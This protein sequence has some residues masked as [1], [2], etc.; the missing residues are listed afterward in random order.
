MVVLSERPKCTRAQKDVE[1]CSHL[2]HPCQISGRYKGDSA[3]SMS[4]RRTVCL[5]FA[6]APTIRTDIPLLSPVRQVVE[7][8]VEQPVEHEGGAQSTHETRDRQVALL[9]GLP[10]GSP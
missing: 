5:R 6:L 10:I 2:R 9:G 1:G 4:S 3:A 8:R 7:H